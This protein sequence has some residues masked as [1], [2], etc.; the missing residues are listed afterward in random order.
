MTPKAVDAVGLALHGADPAVK[1]QGLVKPQARLLVVRP[2]QRDVT[3]A[4]DAVGLAHHVAH[5]TEERQGFVILSARILELR[6]SQRDVAEAPDAPRLSRSVGSP[7]GAH[8]CV[9]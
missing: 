2:S 9:L 5:L 4:P 6:P 7:L 1:W 3:E 8:T